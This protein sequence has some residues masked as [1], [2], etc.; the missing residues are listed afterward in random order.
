MKMLLAILTLI[1]S[2][3]LAGGTSGG[4]GKGVVC[5]N[6]AGQETVELLDLWEARTLFGQAPAPFPPGTTLDTAVDLIFERLKYTFPTALRP[7]NTCGHESCFKKSLAWV[8]SLFLSPTDPNTSAQVIR[9]HGVDLELTDDSFEVARPSKCEIRQIVNYQAGGLIYVDEDRFQKMDLL[10]QAALIAHEALYSHLRGIDNNETNSIRTRR[11]I[12]YVSAGNSFADFTDLHRPKTYVKCD[13]R[14]SGFGFPTYDIDF[15]P[16]VNAE[17]PN[18]LQVLPITFDG[19]SLIG[20]TKW[21]NFI[22]AGGSSPN[23]EHISTGKCNSG[24]G[25]AKGYVMSGPVEFDR[26]LWIGL[27]CDLQTGIFTVTAKSRRPGTTEWTEPVALTCTEYNQ[28]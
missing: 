13:N 7:H 17:I 27:Y 26:G 16:A 21:S 20:I 1:S 15:W 10:N 14:S 24:G 22:S 5:Q 6:S 28:F 3:A 12:G 9:L 4:G 23:Y 2:T 25:S 18:R 11:A 8:A 19:S